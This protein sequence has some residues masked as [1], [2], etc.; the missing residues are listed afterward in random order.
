MLDDAL[1]GCL[2]GGAIGDGIG[3]AYEGRGAV[4]TVDFEIP[5]LIT[6]DTQLTLATCEAILETG[7]LPLARS[8]TVL[9]EKMALRFLQWYSAG[10][11]RGLGAS[12]LKAL[13]DLQMGA[14][15][16]LAGRS[17]EY[18]A[19]NGAAMR[20]APLSFFISPDEDRGLIRD[21]C[22]I[23][24]RNEE[25][26]VGCLAVLYALKSVLDGEGVN[27]A[28][29]ARLL[30]DTLAR[31][32]LLR[33]QEEMSIREA[34][35]MIGCGGQI[36][37]SVPFALFAAGKLGASSFSDILREII[38]CGG[39]T[40]TNASIAGQIM[41]TGLGYSGLPEELVMGFGRLPESRLI[42]E[43]GDRMLKFRGSKG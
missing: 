4:S 26:Y 38:G 20:I 13:R 16:W 37:Q 21:V 27:V 31:D 12:T 3:S 11:L 6:D 30:P 43:L 15:W 17:G 22:W 23:T 35:E 9:P 18:A 34:A 25:A 24:H 29:I 40:D 19:G 28:A 5:W 8:G 14:H 33:L 7:A 42:L 10:R 41:G 32:N 1:L 2:V 36:V 39:D